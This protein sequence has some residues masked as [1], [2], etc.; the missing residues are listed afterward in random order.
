MLVCSCGVGYF[1]VV[2]GDVGLPE[3]D[4]VWFWFSEVYLCLEVDV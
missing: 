4:G 3:G 2:V 1:A